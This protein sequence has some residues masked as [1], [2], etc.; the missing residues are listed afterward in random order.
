MHGHMNVKY[1]MYIRDKK[2]IIESCII[3]RKISDQSVA[4]AEYITVI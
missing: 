1:C 2:T 4:S 3:T